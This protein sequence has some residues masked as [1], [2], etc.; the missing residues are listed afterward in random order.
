MHTSGV[1]CV[2]RTL[3]R[4]YAGTFL[5]E[6]DGLVRLRKRISM[7]H[8]LILSVIFVSSFAHAKAIELRDWVSSPMNDCLVEKTSEFVRPQG[9]DIS[10][11]LDFHPGD[12]GPITTVVARF[13]SNRRHVYSLDLVTLDHW[14]PII[15]ENNTKLGYKTDGLQSKPV[16]HELLSDSTLGTVD[17]SDCL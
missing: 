8:L 12:N 17:V 3:K 5:A 14:V 2:K 10:F 15:E 13:L 1:V 11:L 4:K 7:K 9:D 6:G 16:I